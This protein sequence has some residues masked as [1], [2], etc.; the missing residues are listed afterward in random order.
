MGDS[1]LAHVAVMDAFSAIYDGPNPMFTPNTTPPTSTA[2]EIDP[3]FS[4]SMIGTGGTMETFSH[5][6]MK[7]IETWMMPN[8]HTLICPHSLAGFVSRG[9]FEAFGS[10][11]LAFQVSSYQKSFAEVEDNLRGR[12]KDVAENSFKR[13]ERDIYKAA[14]LDVLEEVDPIADEDAAWKRAKE[15]ATNSRYPIREE[16]FPVTALPLLL[17]AG[18]DFETSTTRVFSYDRSLAVRLIASVR[19]SLLD[20]ASFKRLWAVATEHARRSPLKTVQTIPEPVVETVSG[21]EMSEDGQENLKLFF[22]WVLSMAGVYIT[23][24]NEKEIRNLQNKI[25]SINIS[26]L[27]EVTDVVDALKNEM[28]IT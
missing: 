7:D 9:L 18:G 2:D 3:V 22:E 21:F 8:D 16:G 23:I 27:D 14:Q 5:M 12:W 19:D 13:M 28:K 1:R 6:V 17:S 15:F 24:D 10:L 25:Q 26:S 4:I 11:L 20:E